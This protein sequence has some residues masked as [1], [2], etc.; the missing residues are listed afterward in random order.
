MSAPGIRKGEPRA[1]EAD[2]VHLTTATPSR[3]SKHF[4]KMLA[5]PTHIP[6][7]SPLG[8]SLLSLRFWRREMRE[9]GFATSS[10]SPSLL[11]LSI[12]FS[13]VSSFSSSQAQSRGTEH[14]AQ[15]A[16][17]TPIIPILQR[18][19]RGSETASNFPMV[20]QLVHGGGRS[21]QLISRLGSLPVLPP[22]ILI[23]LKI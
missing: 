15:Q 21:H 18:S 16:Q 17:C 20:T 3:P 14:T 11:L 9:A 5:R 4:F 12:H 7:Q 22:F 13:L 8:S 10:S 19:H 23:F 1:A 6:G 2:C